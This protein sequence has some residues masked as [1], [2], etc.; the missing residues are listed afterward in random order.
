MTVD[1]NSY[2]TTSI[3]INSVKDLFDHYNSAI[4][5]LGYYDTAFIFFPPRQGS[6]EIVPICPYFNVPEN[7][8]SMYL[9]HKLYKLGPIFEKLK[10]TGHPI[11]WEDIWADKE[12]N[13]K[14]YR[15]YPYYK[16]FVEL[17]YEHEY[18]NGFSIPIFGF[19]N[20]FGLFSFSNKDKTATYNAQN[21]VLLYHIC[22]DLFSQYIRISN[23][24]QCKDFKITLREKEVL[25][26]VLNGKSN[27]VIAELIGIS[28][29]TVVTYIRRSAKK[30]G[31]S[32][33]CDAAMTAVLSG[34]LQY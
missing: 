27:S 4:K 22:T 33:K 6:G 17:L 34:S 2:L 23:V 9:T 12:A 10:T 18:E 16:K 25:G 30:L 32:G 14:L 8:I 24:D 15:K 13:K 31:A 5:E 3:N 20:S 29:H 19:S 28:E 1:L 7:I 11:V 26:W 21:L